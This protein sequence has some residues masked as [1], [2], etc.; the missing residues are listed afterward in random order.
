MVIACQVA[1]Y[2]TYRETLELAM[3]QRNKDL[4]AIKD[5]I[6]TEL[7][8]KPAGTIGSRCEKALSNG[9]MR[10]NRSGEVTCGSEDN[11]CGA[12]RVWMAAGPGTADAMWRTIETCQNAKDTTFSYVAARAPLAV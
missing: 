5:L 12:A 2:D 9:T 4:V 11:C 6:V 8:R 1:A 3:I 7:T 10:P